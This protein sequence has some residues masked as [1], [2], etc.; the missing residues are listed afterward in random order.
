[1]RFGTEISMQKP[2][3]RAVGWAVVG[4]VDETTPDRNFP[5]E[6]EVVDCVRDMA[7]GVNYETARRHARAIEK[8]DVSEFCGDFSNVAHAGFLDE[9]DYEILASI[10]HVMSATGRLAFT[11][12]DVYLVTEN[13]NG[14]AAREAMDEMQ[15]RIDRM[16][17]SEITIMHEDG[18][19]YTETPIL[20][21]A[22]KFFPI[23]D[24]RG[25][26]VYESDGYPLLLERVREKVAARERTT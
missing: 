4:L 9:A 19:G 24:G 17:I 3:E 18:T 8:T 11:L 20:P 26:V 6:Q 7:S 1:M 23:M 21:V 15:R 22:K 16:S 25:I 5:S 2:R 12:Q 14:V 13:E 10:D